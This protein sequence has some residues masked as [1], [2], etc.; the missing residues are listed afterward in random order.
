MSSKKSDKKESKGKKYLKKCL[1][2]FGIISVLGTILMTWFLSETITMQYP[3]P[4][5]N[6]YIE[7][8]SGVFTEETE[9]YIMEQAVALNQATKAQIVVMS[10]PDTR[11]DSLE[12]YS[13]KI[14]NDW[15]I[16]DAE[17]DNGVLLLFT[18]TEPHVRLEIGRGL[19]GC[20][21]DSKSGRI[22]DTWAVDAK[23]NGRW[24]KAAVNTFVTVAQEIYAEYGL[25]A[26][27]S[28]DTVDVAEEEVSGT[29]MAD[30]VLPE[31]I[32]EKNT[33][34]FWLQIITAFIVFWIVA[35]IPYLIICLIIYLSANSTGG[36]SSSSG[37]WYSSGGGFGGG[38]GYSGGG[39]SFG[40]GGASR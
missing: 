35:F 33:E 40:G 25:E 8:Y 3:E 34:P 10:V 21:P 38:G 29:T 27:A 16:G 19:E 18:T 7:D 17:L 11:S 5:S 26:P 39:G 28:L 12:V 6:F 4:T 13:Y 22:L 37:G 14:A 15:K 32:V 2:G 24:N 9:T 23:D 36:S 1:Y 20:L 30:A 31:V